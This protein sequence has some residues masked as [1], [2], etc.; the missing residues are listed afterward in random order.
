MGLVRGWLCIR[1]RQ[2]CMHVHAC[3]RVC[4]II[5]CVHIRTRRPLIY[6]FA[7]PLFLIINGVYWICTAAE[8]TILP[9]SGLVYWPTLG[10][11]SHQ[12]GKPYCFRQHLQVSLVETVL[13]RRKLVKGNSHRNK[14]I[15]SVVSMVV[16]KEHLCRYCCG[17][18]GVSDVFNN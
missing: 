15:L 12:T 6:T 18:V 16:G 13:Q 14:G 2:V 1:Y 8:W 17:T 4:I 5:M 7:A 11:K 10:I 9:W 3:V